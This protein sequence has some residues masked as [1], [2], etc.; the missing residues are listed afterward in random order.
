MPPY[1]LIDVERRHL[2]SGALAALDATLH[3]SGG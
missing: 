1:V 3:A 2:A